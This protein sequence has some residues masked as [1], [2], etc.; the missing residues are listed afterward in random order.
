MAS[1]STTP[2]YLLIVG[3]K[4]ILGKSAREAIPELIE[5]GLGE[6]MDGVYKTS[7]P[8][9]GYEFP[10]F[11]EDDQSGQAK[12]AYYNFVIVPLKNPDG[13]TDGIMVHAVNV[14]MQV[15]AAKEAKESSEKFELVLESIPPMAWTA[16]PNGIVNYFSQRWYDY[17]GLLKNNSPDS[18]WIKAIHP[19]ERE[20][21]WKVWNEARESGLSLEVEHRFLKH[22]TQEYRWH[23]VRGVPLKN[24]S[25]EIKFWVGTCT[26]VHD[27]KNFAKAL[28]DNEKQLRLITNNLP[29]FV[30]Y[31]DHTEKY[32]FANK[33]YNN[34]SNGDIEG[35][36]IKEI[37]KDK[38]EI[39]K[40]NIQKALSGEEVTFTMKALLKDQTIKDLEIKY[41]PDFDETGKV[42]GFVVLGID[43]TDRIEIE[44]ALEK[45]NADL[46]RINADLDNFI[47]TA[48]HDLKS[49]V[50]NIEG[51]ILSLIDTFEEKKLADHDINEIMEMINFSIKRFKTTINDLT[52]ISKTQKNIHENTELI[53]IKDIFDEVKY[54]IENQIKESEAIIKADFNCNQINFSRINLKSIFHNLLSNSIKYKSPLRKPI[55]SVKCLEKD[56]TYLIEI[57]DNGLGMKPEHQGKIFGMFKRFHD[58]V[59]GSGVGL[60]LVKRIVDNVNGTI[61]VE[62][63]EGE[64]TSF[65]VFLPKSVIN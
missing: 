15:I 65:R 4:E 51:L 47:Y 48:S 11:Q 10:V 16:L 19:D 54:G 32:L 30:S 50:S 22:T 34:I 7:E 52:E 39:S 59:E 1:R 23:I 44:T 62:S 33:Y 27:I 5:Q 28:E 17:T 45:K 40:P 42:K 41:V 58:H 8:Y 25:G 9:Y 49:P 43:L 18:G 60:Y 53:H 35:K 13:S 36:H 14:T 12:E 56:G 21:A 55:I 3:K 6:V 2:L 63:T 61:E 38:Y 37:V 29:A 24:E 46:L 31:V 26:D 64:G 20:Y 57:S